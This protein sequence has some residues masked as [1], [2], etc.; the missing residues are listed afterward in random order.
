MLLFGSGTLKI[1][2]GGVM[3]K[4]LCPMHTFPPASPP[5]PSLTGSCAEMQNSWVF[6]KLEFLTHIDELA[7]PRDAFRAPV[8][9]SKKKKEPPLNE[10]VTSHYELGLWYTY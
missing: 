6:A 10:T 5:P 9:L 2:W 1:G 8:L 4:D 7:K 3:V